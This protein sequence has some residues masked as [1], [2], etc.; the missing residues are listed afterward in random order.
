MY[1]D[2]SEHTAARLTNLGRSLADADWALPTDLPGW[3]V[4]D[5]FAHL[6]ALESELIGEPP[7]EVALPD[8]LAHVRNEWGAH[9]ERGIEH[10]RARDGADIVE[11]FTRCVTARSA[12]LRAQPPTDPSAPAAHTPGGTAWSW[13]EFLRN[14]VIDLWMHEQDIR[15]AVGQPGGM[16]TSGAR[17]TL[18]SF[19]LALP[20][21]LGKRVAPPAGTV[22]V[23]DIAGP[24]PLTVAVRMD[25]NGRA[26]ALP[27][28]PA[29]ATVRMTMD[30]ETFAIL[31]GGRRPPAAVK[32]RV[33]GDADLASR[34][35]AAMSIT[36]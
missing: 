21:V 22:A 27:E 17:V 5:V 35:L 30:A 7:P 18:T 19:A 11:E 25:E 36:S 3:S 32:V 24:V 9:M 34:A 28:P 23:W 8:G 10:R 33:E 12:A 1:V 20:Y 2:A 4:K 16:D 13:E 14:R 26:T 6:A 15:R 29:D 31:A